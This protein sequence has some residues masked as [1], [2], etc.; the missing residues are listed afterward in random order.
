MLLSVTLT[1]RINGREADDWLILTV[2]LFRSCYSDTGIASSTRRCI[3][4]LSLLRASLFSHASQQLCTPDRWPATM[5]HFRHNMPLTG[6]LPLLKAQ[7]QLS[8]VILL[9]MKNPTIVFVPFKAAFVGSVISLSITTAVVPVFYSSQEVNRHNCH[10]V[11]RS[12]HRNQPKIS[13]CDLTA[14][15]QMFCHG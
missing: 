4:T 5:W 11:W 9:L 8:A 15:L 3:M 2:L 14:L 13:R 6:Q 10:P 1:D 7:Y 12:N